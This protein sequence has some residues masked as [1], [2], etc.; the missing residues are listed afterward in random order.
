MADFYLKSGSGATARANSTAYVLGDR[1]VIARADTSANYLVARAWVLECTTAGTSGAAVPTWPATVTQ[2]TTTV[3]DGTVT[4]TCR[5]PGFSSGTTANWTFAAIYD[6][7][8]ASAMAAGDRLFV[9]NNHASSYAA[10]LTVSFPGTPASPNQVL[11]VSDAAAP[12][13]ALA[14]TATVTTTGASDITWNGS[15]YCY[16]IELSA[17]SGAVNSYMNLGSAVA[18]GTTQTYKNCTFKLAATSANNK[19]FIGGVVA[20]Q[21]VSRV[22]WRNCSF[23]FTA[24][25]H[26]VYTRM[27]DL[28]I[29]GLSALAGTTSPTTLFSTGSNQYRGRIIASGLDLTNLVAAV[30]I[31]SAGVPSIGSI[32]NSKLPASWTGSLVSGTMIPGERYTMHNCDSADTNYRI[33]QEG[34]AGSV[35]SETTLVRTGGSGDG[36]TTLS[37]KMA[38]SA[39]AEYPLILLESG[40]IHSEWIDTVGAAKTVTVEILHDSTTNLKDDE[41][42]LDVQ[43]LGTTG[44]PLSLFA[45]DAKADVFATAADQTASTATWTTTGLTNPN[46]QKLAVTFTPQE[47]GVAICR[48]MLAKASYTVYVDPM[49]TVS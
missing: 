20:N 48:V 33:W 5:K 46:K 11:C 41:I 14:A 40:E 2:D 16:G 26:Q 28:E 8:V 3:T 45:N 4:W 24:A 44:F 10:H 43:Y 29:Q 6:D 30:N 21:P 17:G 42:W 35:R 47:K 38:T 19:I 31:F 13:T 1:V 15:Q 36:T 34:Y 37:W 25:A 7:Y 23:N 49:A 9:S 12:P 27:G 39:N 32:R 22:L 18:G